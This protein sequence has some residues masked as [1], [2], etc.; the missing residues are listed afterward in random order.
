MFSL[1]ALAT[2]T[3]TPLVGNLA[4]ATSALDSCSASGNF[5]DS[6]APP[7]PPNAG[8]GKA[9]AELSIGKSGVR[10]VLDASGRLNDESGSLTDSIHF[11]TGKS[12]LLEDRPTTDSLKALS[13]FL[14]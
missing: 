3:A 11:A 9:T 4:T 5:T 1:L 7:P 8:N 12:E 13:Q 10:I 6:A 2:V 14:M